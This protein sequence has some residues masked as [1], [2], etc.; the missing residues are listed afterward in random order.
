[1]QLENTLVAF[2]MHKNEKIMQLNIFVMCQ[3][4]LRSQA[5]G[6]FGPDPAAFLTE[7]GTKRI[8]FLE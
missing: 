8:M 3:W 6:C 5:S 7:L 4:Q 2:I 1:M